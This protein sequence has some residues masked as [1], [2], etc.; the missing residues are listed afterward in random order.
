MK[1]TKVS[2]N[3]PTYNS[4]KT[5]EK[6]LESVKKQTYK[7][8]ELVIIDSYS[9]DRTIEIAKKFKCKIIMC[10]HK[11]LE[12]RIVGAEK[13]TG[14]YVLFLD[15]DQILHEKTI[16]NAVK[17]MNKYDYLW[18]YERTYN[19]EKW[20]PSLYE[21]DRLLVQEMLI[22]KNVDMGVVLPRFFDRKI[23][24]KA[25]KNISRDVAKICAGQDHLI[26]EHEVRK[27]SKKRG[28]VGNLKN[29]AVEHIEPENFFELI[30][31][32]KRWGKT[33]KDLKKRKI[34]AELVTARHSFR[35]IYWKHPIWSIKSFILRV[36][37]GIPYFIG[38]YFGR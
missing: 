12:A 25:M 38:Y 22:N 21:A 28:F 7:N 20:V 4:E 17:Q 37:R 23:L 26:I 10:K 24:L 5:L 11:L 18:L 19:R 13:S 35:K 14:K 15:S 8:I 1:N 33:T 32:Q 31:K 29:P 27:V 2:I 16:E 34:Y 9:K 30:K 6:T 3:I 36:L